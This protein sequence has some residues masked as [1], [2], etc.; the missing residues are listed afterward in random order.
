MWFFFVFYNSLINIFY[1]KENFKYIRCYL[2]TRLLILDK[3]LKSRFIFEM[4]RGLAECT[5]AVRR[6]KL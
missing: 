2:Y 4:E 1:K 3:R 6:F 5:T